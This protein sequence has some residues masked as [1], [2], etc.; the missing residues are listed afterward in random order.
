MSIRRF[1]CQSWRS[2]NLFFIRPRRFR[3]SLFLSMLS[4][5]YDCNQKESFEKLFGNLWI[6]QHPTSLQG[7]YQVL[8]L[9]DLPVHDRFFVFF[10]QLWIGFLPFLD[11]I[12]CTPGSNDCINH[13][14]VKYLSISSC[15]FNVIH[16][17]LSISSLAL[18]SFACKSGVIAL[19][20]V[21]I[22]FVFNCYLMAKIIKNNEK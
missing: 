4:S 22:S 17:P 10:E 12:F 7:I 6:G 14:L 8:F 11:D 16:C 13:K 18:S 19:V 3:K 1:F 15:D 9:G 21:L 20:D 2:R 5:Y